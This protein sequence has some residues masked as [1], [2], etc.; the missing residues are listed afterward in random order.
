MFHIEDAYYPMGLSCE[1]KDV[2]LDNVEMALH[3][4]Q[5]MDDC[6]YLENHIQT[7]IFFLLEFNF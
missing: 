1:G 6:V 4:V 7:N 2:F 5:L 3:W